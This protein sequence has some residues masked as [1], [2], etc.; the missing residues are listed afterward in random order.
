MHHLQPWT[1][2]IK[3]LVLIAL[4]WASAASMRGTNGPLTFRHITT[5]DRL[6]NSMIHRVLQDEKGFMWVATF[7]GLYRYDGYEF[8]AYKSKADTPNYL[9]NNN[10]ICMLN[11]GKLLWL[12]THGGLCVLDKSTNEIRPLPVPAFNKHRVNVLCTVSG[13]VYMGGIQGVAYYDTKKKRMTALTPANSHGDV[14]YKVN[15]QGICGDGRGNLLIATWRKGLYLYSPRKRMFVHYPEILGC[16]SFLCLFKDASGQIWLG[17]NGHGV[18]KLTFDTKH[19]IHAKQFSTK[20][21]PLPSDFVYAFQ[22]DPVSHTLWVGTRK[23]IALMNMPD[24]QW[25]IQDSSNGDH[26]NI[27]EVTDIFRDSQ[28]RMWVSTKGSGIFYTEN[29]QSIFHLVPT[30]N[31][32]RLQAIAVEPNGALWC[33]YGYGVT[34]QRGSLRLSLLQDKR[35]SQIYRLKS[36]GHVLLTTHNDGL[37]ECLDGRIVN[38]YSSRNCQFVPHNMVN[39]IAEDRYG[40]LWVASYEGLGV[41][42]ANGQGLIFRKAKGVS[43]LLRQDMTALMA[44]ADGSLWIILQGNGVVRLSGNGKQVRSLHC[45]HYHTKLHNMPVNSALCLFQDSHK[46]IWLGT[47]GGGLCIYDKK[48]K[49]FVSVHDRYHLPGDMATSIQEDRQGRLWVG[50]NQGL[51]CIDSRRKA[52]ASVRIFSMRDGLPD[53]FFEPRASCP[54]ADKLYF[55]TSAGMVSFSPS[56]VK[57]RNMHQQTLVAGILI[58]GQPFDDLPASMRDAI[59]HLSPNYTQRLVMPPSVKDFTIQFATISAIDASADITYAYRLLGYNSNWQFAN[60]QARNATY[61]QLSPGTYTFELKATD[62]EGH[63]SGTKR[64]TI[65]VRPPFYATPWAYAVYAILA[66]AL[67]LLIVHKTRKRMMLHNKLQMQVSETG[68]QVV[69]NH[70]GEQK[71][72][73]KKTMSF[74]IKD[75]DYK[76][77]DEQL[78]T[79]A[80]RSIN[81]HLADANYGTAQLVADVHV[82]RTTLFKK[83][84]ALTGMNASGLIRNVR[85]KAARQLLDGKPNARISDVAYQVGFSDPKYFSQC[86]KK[87]FDV[88]PKEYVEQK[89][90]QPHNSEESDSSSNSV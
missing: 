52:E 38:H 45:E 37:Y 73:D 27:K 6:P 59:T 40:N 89:D 42:H 11:E 62:E 88:T 21:T 35:V 33:A 58:N 5:R 66:V 13:T 36:N 76:D 10:V 2:K 77:S 29:R 34:Y 75:L 71:N 8:S 50:T 80:I 65:V 22:E 61:T 55:G 26:T 70:E 30:G 67:I 49:Q 78:L 31:S 12:G 56:I 7:Y 23:G 90:L 16:S 44:D 3:F 87:E 53:N 74:E 20:N 32:S 64:I 83:L 4:L 43:P 25:V 17:S 68:V 18:Y 63:W 82:S 47:E 19:G 69:L 85:L 46:R 51:V 79:D 39:G 72:A 60:S 15:V 86:F 48:R 14:P 81:A 9:P 28:G 57:D 24:K 41:R 84:K 1:F 54:Q